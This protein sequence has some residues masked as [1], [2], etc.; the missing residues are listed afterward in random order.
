[1]RCGI[2]YSKAVVINDKDYIDNETKVFLRPDEFKKLQGKD[3]KIKQQFEDY[4]KL[5]K[6]AKIDETVP[7]R[8]Y[9]LQFSTLQYFEQYI[10]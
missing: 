4:I 5:Y 1:M 9:I 8:D 7:Y 6:Q 10:Y 2:D 3:Y